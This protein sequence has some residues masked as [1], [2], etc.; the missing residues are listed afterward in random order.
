MSIYRKNLML[1]KC[2][3]CTLNGVLK[4]VTNYKAM[5][6]TTMFLKSASTSNSNSQKKINA[7]RANRITIQINHSQMKKFNCFHR[8]LKQFKFN[9]IFCDCFVI[10]YCCIVNIN[11]CIFIASQQRLL[12]FFWCSEREAQK[13][14][15]QNY[16]FISLYKSL[17]V[18]L[19]YLS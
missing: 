13:R 11:N 5:H 7:T 2:T 16:Y 18:T 1:Q 12:C 19:P 4:K 14:N 15:R 6:S 9:Y 17:E 8:E 3:E 10:C